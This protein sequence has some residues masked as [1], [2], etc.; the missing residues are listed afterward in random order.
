[1]TIRS[2][3]RKLFARTPRTA[4]KAPDRCRPR[5]EALEDRLAP[6]I[7]TV[8]SM[9]DT[10][11]ATDAYLSLR[12]AIAIVNSA[13]LPSGLSSQITGQISGN[14]H[15]GK[16]D[17]IEFDPTKVT[18]AITL[19]GTQLEL[20]LPSTTA[21]ITI[22]GGAAGVTV[23]GNQ[24][25]RIFQVDSGVQANF[26]NLTITHGSDGFE[27]GGIRNSGNL[28]VSNCTLSDN[29]CADFGGGIDNEGGTLA[30][31]NCTLSGNSGDYGG[32]IFNHAGSSTLAV[33]NCT[34]SG[35]SATADGGGVY[36]FVGNDPGIRVTVNNSIVANN[37]GGDISNEYTGDH[38]LT[39]T[40]ALGLLAN[41][42]GPTQTMALPPDSPAIGAGDPTGAP[43]WDQRG[44]GFSR[45][46]NGK[47]DIGAFE[48]QPITLNTLLSGT[49]S[50]LYSQTIKASEAGFVGTFTFN[51]TGTL[52]NGLTLGTDG[53]LSGT[54]TAAGQFTFTVTVKDSGG[55][56][57]SQTYTNF[58]VAKAT[59]TATANANSKTYG[60]TASDTGTLSGVVTGD[61][62]TASFASPSDAATAP[63][64]TGSYTI[65]ASFSDPNNKLSNYTVQETD[66]TLTVQKADLYVTAN[67]NSKI[68]GE[69]ASDSGTLNGVVSNDGITA[70]F[71]SAGD[72]AAAAAG[73]Y[74]ITATLSDPN[75][76]LSNYTVHETDATLTVLSYADATTSLQAQVDGAGL[77]HGMQNSLD[78]QLQAA[79]ASFAAGDPADGVSELGAFLNHVSA[80]RGKKIGAG[81][82]DAW[83][84]YAQR[85]ITAVG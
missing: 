27:G 14:L 1:M 2:W 47:I 40:V 12:E 41:N 24:A 34:L 23:D 17:T 55:F 16:A 6:A 45:V 58:T 5:L 79:I 36:G 49:Y 62:I 60:Q 57:A 82:A 46:V 64:G 69:T 4:R 74:T 9:A 3:T 71:A 22:D 84:A 29:H 85:I 19:G 73:S 20:S 68:Q 72:T 78:S 65:S 13:T 59:L 28:I 10:A 21:A 48:V 66:A 11:N 42:G 8:N 37:S 39:G 63:V 52:P 32:G 75:G 33:S 81:L 31:S 70:S 18:S 51:V 26:T 44:P 80:Q 53:T 35:N 56:T 76:K 61:G 43:Q 15:D 25:S 38:N 30:V 54:P 67:P 50:T 7:L 83:I 77:A